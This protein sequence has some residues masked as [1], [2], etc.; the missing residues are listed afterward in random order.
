[1]KKCPYCAEEIQ[2]EAI[3]CRY[4]REILVE[5]HPSQTQEVKAK[6]SVAD[7]VKIGVGMF[8][9]L[10]LILIGAV[11]ALFLLMP[12]LG[13]PLKGIENIFVQQSEK[14]LQKTQ[15]E[16][17]NQFKRF[18][19]IKIQKE[20]DKYGLAFGKTYY[21]KTF[22]GKYYFSNIAEFKK[23]ETEYTNTTAPKEIWG[24]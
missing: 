14:S 10:P 6:S 12:I 8:I 15:K 13:A 19:D 22:W 17:D 5:K 18:M 11:A 4:C 1:M 23:Y 24:S 7:G 21:G 9:V 20:P 16:W 2:E 3:K